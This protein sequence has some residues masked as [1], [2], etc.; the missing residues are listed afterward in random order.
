MPRYQEQTMTYQTLELRRVE[1]ILYV[2]FCNPPINLMNVQM[3]KEL[4]DLGGSLAF[5]PQVRVVVFG[6]ANPDFFIAHFDL[7]DLLVSLDDPAVAKSR[8]EDINV[9]QALATMWQT[10]PQVTIAMVDGICRGAGLEFL[11][12]IKMTFATP[13]SRLCLPELAGGI[14]P[15]GGGSTRLIMQI[16]PARAREVILSSRDFSGDE[17]AAYGVIN[18]ALP[19]DQLT[20]YVEALARDVAK[21]PAEAVAAVDRVIKDIGGLAVDALFKGFA[22]ENGSVNKLLADPSVKQG[23]QKMAALQDREHELDLAATL[24]PGR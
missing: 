4:F 18:R 17:A 11:L 3:V 8:Y 15:A 20:A 7:N 5:D 22:S 9:V 2:D 10:L 12:A 6:S 23:L 13:Q 19:R 21:R 16:G 1:Q 14:L 24:A